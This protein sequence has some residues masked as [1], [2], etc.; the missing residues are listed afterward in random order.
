MKTQITVG[1]AMLAGFGLGIVAISGL[2]AQVKSTVY[3]VEE[4]DVSNLDAFQKEFAPKIGAV[5]KAAGIRT[6]VAGGKVTVIDGPPPKGRVV[7]QA[8]DSV[9][10]AQAF[11]NSPEFKEA[12][13]IGDKYATYRSFLVEGVPQ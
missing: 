6:L 7:I 10:N 9:E 12:K 13:A 5:N 4:I 3:L 2:H 1:M 8:W 11:R